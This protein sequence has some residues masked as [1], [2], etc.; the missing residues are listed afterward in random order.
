MTKRELRQIDK[1][2]KKY[3]RESRK[4]EKQKAKRDSK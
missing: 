3:K 1:R 2:I 4:K